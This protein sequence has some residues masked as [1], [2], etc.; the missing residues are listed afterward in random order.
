MYETV[1]IFDGIFEKNQF[2]S[3]LNN[4]DKLKNMYEKY[5]EHAKKLVPGN[6]RS[7]IFKKFRLKCLFR[8]YDKC[9][10][11]IFHMK[12]RKKMVDYR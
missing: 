8:I 7:V 4:F 12:E 11:K 3:L 6:L 10:L 1:S 2:V 5:F 9:Y